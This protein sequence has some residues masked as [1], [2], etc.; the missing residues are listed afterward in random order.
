MRRFL[1]SGAAGVAALLCSVALAQA[2]EPL[3]ETVHLVVTG[4]AN[5]GTYNASSTRGGCSAGATGAGSWGNQ[6]SD[7]KDKD[8]KHFNSLQLIVP[9]AKGAAHG[10][11]SFTL[12]VGF[13]PLMHRGAEYNVVTTGAKTKGSGTV[14]VMD[15]GT[16]ARVDFDVKTA[17]G[18]KLAGTIDCKQVMRM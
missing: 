1:G 14:T 8:P 10:T 11:K 6:L 13:G 17:D 15:H 3:T 4:G 5:A 12:I 18:V 2:A 9:D 16:T 7:P